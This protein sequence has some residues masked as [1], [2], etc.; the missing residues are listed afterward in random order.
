MTSRRENLQLS[1]HN[2][3]DAALQA[4][5][6]AAE[7]Q[8]AEDELFGLLMRCRMIAGS[9]DIVLRLA[10]CTLRD[11]GVTWERIAEA[12]SMSRQA[13]WQKFHFDCAE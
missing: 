1:L 6:L 13:A 7:D 9:G 2:L 10:V 4:Y 12:L 5:D 8:L 3:A 11:E